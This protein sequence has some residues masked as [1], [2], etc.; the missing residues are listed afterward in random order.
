MKNFKEDEKN[1]ADT[2]YLIGSSKIHYRIN[3]KATSK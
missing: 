1:R 2:L 3:A